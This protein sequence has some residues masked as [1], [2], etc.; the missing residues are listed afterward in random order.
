MSDRIGL[1][2]ESGRY[3]TTNESW[4]IFAGLYL[5]GY[6]LYG[7]GLPNSDT[8]IRKILQREEPRIIVVQDR[9][10]W[11][12][13]GDFREPRAQ[14]VNYQYLRDYPC[15]KATIL[16]DAQQNPAATSGWAKEM[17]IDAHIIYYDEAIVR[18]MNPWLGPVIRTW[19]TIDKDTVPAY[20]EPALDTIVSGF[21]SSVY[22]LRKRIVEDQHNLGISVLIHPGYH[23]NGCCTPSYL[24]I[25]A[26]YKVSICTCSI[27][28]YALRKIIESTAVG[29]TVITNLPTQYYPPGIEENLIHIDE[30]IS[31]DKLYEL[32]R[33]CEEEYEPE[34]QRQIALKCQQL[35]DY[36]VVC[37]KLADDLEVARNW[38][39]KRGK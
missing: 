3:H 12:Y 37:K 28:Q 14:F 16:K 33:Y 4:Q 31:F 30:D 39:Y 36:R 10:E 2:V 23:R 15:F 32:I 22:P 9:R 6:E 27:Y 11:D 5:N 20:Q 21:V 25:L 17:G 38:T 18:K 8:D 1:A 24:R 26:K 35:Y 13:K 19:H 29:C 7:Y 34:E